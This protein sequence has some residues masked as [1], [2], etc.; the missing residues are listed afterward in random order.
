MGE[1]A[2]ARERCSQD[3]DCLGHEPTEHIAADI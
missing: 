3:S 2:R 1:E